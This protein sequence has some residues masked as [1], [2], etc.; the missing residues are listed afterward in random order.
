MCHEFCWDSG[1]RER[2]RAEFV[3]GKKKKHSSVLFLSQGKNRVISQNSPK[4]LLFPSVGA[5]PRSRLMCSPGRHPEQ[6][7]EPEIAAGPESGPSHGESSLG[8]FSALAAAAGLC[9]AP[10]EAALST[11]G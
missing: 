10:W 11:W 9:R 3:G 5:V 1:R 8:W 4:W 2:D 6:G 7:E